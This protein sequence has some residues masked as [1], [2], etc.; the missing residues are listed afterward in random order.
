MLYS[1][2]YDNIFIYKYKSTDYMIPNYHSNFLEDSDTK[3][4]VWNISVNN[5]WDLHF[6]PFKW[7]YTELGIKE[8]TRKE[9]EQLIPISELSEITG[10]TNELLNNIES[11]NNKGNENITKQLDNVPFRLAFW[12]IPLYYNQDIY[13]KNPFTNDNKISKDFIKDNLDKFDIPLTVNTNLNAFNG[14][15]APPDSNLITNLFTENLFLFNNKIS[16]ILPK[17]CETF[18][19]ENQKKFK[20]N[21]WW[22]EINWFNYAI[23]SQTAS[24]EAWK[25]EVIL[26]KI[27][28]SRFN[29]ES[30]YYK[31]DRV[32]T[33]FN[34]KTLIEYYIN[35]YSEEIWYFNKNKNIYIDSLQILDKEIVNKKDLDKYTLKLKN[36]LIKSWSSSSEA[37]KKVNKNMYKY[38]REKSLF[39]IEEK[40]LKLTPPVILFLKDLHKNLYPENHNSDISTFIKKH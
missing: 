17:Q 5:N 34:L 26:N 7:K 29:K 39:Y 33:N 11:Q 28:T 8:D 12:N 14:Y 31:R 2:Y 40:N 25:T 38:D 35:N 3:F 6:F 18:E 23:D 22:K 20:I 27:T 36:N 24:I 10:V 32:Y 19:I 16:K 9:Y 30:D 37:E 13:D 4:K 1:W 21:V 15:I